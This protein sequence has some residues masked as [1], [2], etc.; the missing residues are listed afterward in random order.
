[1][2][3]ESLP[4]LVRGHYQV[5]EWKHAIAILRNDFPTEFNDIVAVLSDFRLQKNDIVA[6]GGGKSPI[7][8]ALDSAFFGRGWEK[9]TFRTG[10]VVD[11]EKLENPTHEIDCYKNRVALEVEADAFRLRLFGSCFRLLVSRLLSGLNLGDQLGA[12]SYPIVARWKLKFTATSRPS[13]DVLF[14]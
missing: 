3:I 6:P 2:A 11:G 5:H 8:R 7:A 9:K 10:V 13:V 1:M 12:M 4:P 14:G